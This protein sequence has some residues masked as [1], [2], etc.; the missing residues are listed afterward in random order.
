MKK[1][2]MAAALAVVIAAGG[3]LTGCGNKDGSQKTA[4]IKWYIP[5]GLTDE[6]REGAGD[7]IRE[8]LNVEMDFVEI[9]FGDYDQK[10][11]V[12]NAANEEYD[13]AF[14]SS[15]CNNYNKNIVNG[16]I[17]E[18][19]ELMEKYGKGTYA[20]MSP[21]IWDL[22]RVNGKLYGVINQQI[23]G[24]GPC[25]LIPET[26]LSKLG[27]SDEDFKVY[28]DTEKYFRKV[29]ELTGKYTYV[30]EI[31][32]HWLSVFGFDEVLGQTIPGAIYIN[33]T[34]DDIKIVNQ[35][36]SQ[37]FKDFINWRRR[38]TEEGLTPPNIIS[39]LD[40]AEIALNSGDSGIVNLLR[41][42]TTYKPELDTELKE[43]PNGLGKI[44]CVSLQQPYMN[45]YSVTSTLNSIAATSKNPEKA[46][47]VLELINTDKDLFNFF[48][49]GV[50]GIDY[51]KTGENTIER[52]P[53][54]KYN[55]TSAWSIGN[56]FNMYTN[57]VQEPNIH[58]RTQKIN[59]ESTKSPLNGFV[60][61]MES[62]K[63][64]VSNCTA[65]VDE[66]LKPLDSGVVDVNETYTKFIEK[67][68]AA[69]V[70]EIIDE[71]NR[72]LDEWKK[73]Q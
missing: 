28:T 21:E 37:E 35:Y 14:T 32:K 47:Q 54:R 6:V 16:T 36:E 24:R 13:I 73:Q 61:D 9:S 59:D 29:K 11:Q 17:I 58:E 43:L 62:I 44:K 39:N 51:K 10:M 23:M 8:K 19:D 71:L 25:L 72:Q 1:R 57:E 31:W 66:F 2:L 63:T 48:A 55:Q 68:K 33:A 5:I 53:D 7:Y 3:M 49:W 42:E 38:M 12:L 52:L 50:E 64:Q 30:S 34:K 60:A 65:V 15:W 20:L 26:S 70:D 27:M 46:M 40:N 69:G 56:T 18:L 45:T 67:L 4:G 41:F 22:S